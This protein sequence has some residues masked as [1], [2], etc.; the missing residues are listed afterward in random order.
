MFNVLYAAVYWNH[1]LNMSM[2]IVCLNMFMFMEGN[3]GNETEVSLNRK[4]MEWRRH[5]GGTG[6]LN[7]QH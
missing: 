1:G 2:L 5:R 4:K 3:T 6:S 7:I